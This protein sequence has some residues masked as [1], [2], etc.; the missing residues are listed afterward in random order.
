ML[1]HV[2][3][4]C[5]VA[6]ESRDAEDDAAEDAARDGAVLGTVL[7]GMVLAGTGLAGTALA[8][9]ARAGTVLAGTLLPGMMLALLRAR[10]VHRHAAAG[11]AQ[12]QPGVSPRCGPAHWSPG[13]CQNRSQQATRK[14]AQWKGWQ[15]GLRETEARWEPHKRIRWVAQQHQGTCASQ[16]GRG[17]RR[18]GTSN[19]SCHP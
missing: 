2:T 10:A 13:L 15:E 12:W 16:M 3:V 6:L 17:R 5:P 7:A 9:M 14:A 11:E 8:G 1:V 4:A 19:N 18:R